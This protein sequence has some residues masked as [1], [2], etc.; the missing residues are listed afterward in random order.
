MKVQTLQRRP[1]FQNKTVISTPGSP[2]MGKSSGNGIN[3]IESPEANTRNTRT[4]QEKGTQDT[5]EELYHFDV[6][7]CI[8]FFKENN[9]KI[10][11]ARLLLGAQYGMKQ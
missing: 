9:N 3:D 8:H 10:R 7:K 2:M 6:T 5:A 11:F 1:L 4:R